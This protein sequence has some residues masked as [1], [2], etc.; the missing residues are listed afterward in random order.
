M[1]EIL[2]CSATTPDQTQAECPSFLL[3]NRSHFK[4]DER[5]KTKG[6]CEIPTNGTHTHTHTHTSLIQWPTV[7]RHPSSRSVIHHC[8]Y[9]CV[10]VCVCVYLLCACVSVYKCAVLPN[11]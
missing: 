4:L 8:V 3:S 6:M 2:E 11:P 1:I 9:V 10:C 5:G 7:H